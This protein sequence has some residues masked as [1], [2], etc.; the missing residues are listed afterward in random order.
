MNAENIS[1][2]TVDGQGPTEVARLQVSALVDG[3]LD[4]EVVEHAID[5]LLASD[6]LADFWADAHRAGDWMRSDEVVGVGD[7][8][9]FLQRF[10]AR[11]ATEPTILA[12]VA[13]RKT[14]VAWSK[15]FWVRTGLP[16]ASVAAALVVVAW[17]AMPSNRDGGD[18]LAS[19]TPTVVI[20]PAATS[21]TDVAGRAPLRAVDPERL[22]DYFAAHR[23]VTPFGYRGATARPA[24]YSPPS[25]ANDTT[26]S[27]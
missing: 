9:R 19:A 7:G 26:P 17:V 23:D 15:R 21:E 13:A 2:R 12:P 11:L 5:A 20:V 3:E 8:Q 25:A 14:S 27:H 4:D 24:A 1:L 6:E 16:G 22:S 18:K 10:S